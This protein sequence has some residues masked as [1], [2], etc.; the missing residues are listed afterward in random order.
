MR[1]LTLTLRDFMSHGNTE[2]D[3]TGVPAAVVTGPNGAGKSSLIDGIGWILWGETRAGTDDVVRLG[4]LQASGTVTFSAGGMEYRVT[5]TRKLNGRGTS[6]LEF[7]VA[8]SETGSGWRSLAGA[9]LRDTEAKI[10]GIVGAYDL[11]CSTWLSRQG[12]ADQFARATPGER[13]AIIGRLLGL[14]K[15]SGFRARAMDLGRTAERELDQHEPRRQA[16]QA[17]IDTIPER[18][19][20]LDAKRTG[21]ADAQATERAATE[22]VDEATATRNRMAAQHSDIRE[23]RAILAAA[24]RE[25]EQAR[26]AVTTRQRTIETLADEVEALEMVDGAWT[27]ENESTL[28]TMRLGEREMVAAYDAAAERGHLLA[29]KVRESEAAV[30]AAHQDIAAESSAAREAW[31]TERAQLSDALNA[32][33]ARQSEALAAS[34]AAERAVAD[35]RMKAREEWQANRSAA[36]AAVA[37]AER[38]EQ[39]ARQ[40]AETADRDARVAERDAALLGQV[41]CGGTGEFAGCQFLVRAAE[42]KRDAPLL[43]ETAARARERLQGAERNTAAA[44]DGLASLGQAAPE[45]VPADLAGALDAARARYAEAEQVASDAGASLRVHGHV[46]PAPAPSQELASRLADADA[47]L[48]DA[49]A[50]KSQAAEDWR[51]A[52]DRLAT[53]RG[54]IGEQEVRRARGQEIARQIADARSR[55]LAARD[56]L[57]R[58]ESEAA[59]LSGVAESRRPAAQQDRNLDAEL[60][61]VQTVLAERTRERDAATTLVAEAAAAVRGSER[62]VAEAEKA[63][64]DMAALLTETADTRRRAADLVTLSQAY[65]D[66]PQLIVETVIPDIEATANRLLARVSQSG[67]SISIRTQRILKSDRERVAETLDLIVRDVVGERPYESY[68]GG[69]RF[70]VD[71]ALRVALAHVLSARAGLDLRTLVVD[72][73][74][75][76]LDPAG[77]AGF[78]S[79]LPA[80]A[81]LFGLCL[82][83]SHV[84]ELAEAF[85]ARLEVVKT[86]AGSVAEWR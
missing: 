47:A 29:D 60:A 26:V 41:P 70:R 76:A 13:R 69:E 48:L 62:S 9:N 67:L 25:A 75:G 23:A 64:E 74:F 72:E 53:L 6:S 7:E 66:V 45:T 1:L 22:G 15:W 59:R 86:A 38:A 20:D 55:L 80:T 28:E 12:Q 8:G 52:R 65:Q 27:P 10:A 51:A 24:L 79:M 5:R 68:S 2:I 43:V 19:A 30:A 78:A 31:Q 49:M 77:I 58:E 82:V 84:P 36:Q 83:I 73:G 63:S 56:E 42:A 37:A 21:L 40:A 11:A 34:N 18:I 81:D 32:A 44:R 14:E 3:L 54:K 85:P 46:P 33:Q 50:D 17:I 71:W 39:I 4:Q 61:D 16:L 35:A 57:K